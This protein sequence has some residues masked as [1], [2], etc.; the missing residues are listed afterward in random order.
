MAL[1][2]SWIT[3]Q[4]RRDGSREINLCD[5]SGIFST[6]GKNRLALVAIFGKA[7]QGKSFLMNCLSGEPKGF[8][9]SNKK[10]PCTVGIDLANK[11]M[12]LREFGSVD[13]GNCGGITSSDST[14]MRVGF[15]DAEGQGD[16][17]VAYDAK[18]VCPILLA[19]KCVIFNWK[20]TLQKDSILNQLGI[21]TRA[22]SN[23]GDDVH[24]GGGKAGGGKKFGHLHIVFRD[25]SSVDGTQDSVYR[26]LFDQELGQEA[27][28]RNQIRR[29][30]IAAFESVQIHLF[31]PPVERTADLKKEL[32]INMTTGQF[33]AQVRNL[34]ELMVQQLKQSTVV[35]GVVLTGSNV[36][37]VVDLVVDS[38][39]RGQTVQPAAMYTSMMR[40]EVDL[41]RTQIDDHM[42]RSESEQ[43]QA[44]ESYCR[45]GSKLIGRESDELSKLSKSLD[46]IIAD[47]QQQVAEMTKSLSG[48]TLRN[49][50][51]D[52]QGE[53]LKRSKEDR[54]N[55]FKQNYRQ[56]FAKWL[57]AALKVAKRDIDD[58]ISRLEKEKFSN[59][60]QIE[61]RL[62]E[63]VDSVCATR[64]GLG[65]FPS[66]DLASAVEAVKKY[67]SEAS[68]RIYKALEVLA[69][70]E[71]DTFQKS[72][73]AAIK[74][75]EDSISKTARDL[76]KSHPTGYG[77]V[78]LEET[79]NELFFQKQEILETQA[80]GTTMEVTVKDDFY[81]AVKDKKMRETMVEN[82]NK[83][84]V[85]SISNAV[86]TAKNEAD[87]A[88]KEMA[89]GLTPSHVYSEDAIEL[90]LENVK[91]TNV[92]NTKKRLVGWDITATDMSAL[93]ADIEGFIHHESGSLLKQFKKAQAEERDKQAK[94]EK[95]EKEA[96]ERQDKINAKLQSEEESRKRREADLARE[97]EERQSKL[98]AKHQEIIKRQETEA[99]K[100]A[101]EERKRAEEEAKKRAQEERKRAEQEAKEAEAIA[102]SKKLNEAQAQDAAAKNSRKGRSD[103]Q[104]K[105][106]KWAQEQGLMD[107]KGRV[108]KQKPEKPVSKRAGGGGGAAA[109]AGGGG[110]GRGKRKRGD[111][112][113]EM[114]TEEEPDEGL[115]VEKVVAKASSRQVL[116]AAGHHAREAEEQRKKELVEKLLSKGG[117]KKKGKK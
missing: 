23:V 24:V 50:N 31:D 75:M 56:V 74:E 88:L 16:R 72:F 26:T 69:V 10:D 14:N 30:V 100:R 102:L 19:A 84:V 80:E 116:E 90:Q 37:K 21:M 51:Q 47:F 117:Q 57:D 12:G 113:D 39:N 20:E 110:G 53:R 46:A 73:L 43:L 81:K 48:E 98:N 36:C 95:K 77:I 45:D 4:E 114:D 109:A 54:V 76:S 13:G 79:L 97:E 85:Q 62:K 59:K 58:T 32:T 103:E 40:A 66:N 15:V 6:V 5:L 7:R 28:V 67:A 41:L 101:Q 63:I 91:S 17:D 11:L 82:Y 18:L 55:S 29:D 1:A 49:V 108:I 52:P 106:L 61:A 105:A 99:K 96:K 70:K 115:E 89:R 64:V 2:H 42:R 68:S 8:K 111:S 65:I 104:I 86:A 38:L 87:S 94:Q 78:R 107:E 25:W 3:S 83:L 112:E 71:R 33:R 60:A 44:L 27:N 92:I 22:A 93:T 34:R 9:I 35:G